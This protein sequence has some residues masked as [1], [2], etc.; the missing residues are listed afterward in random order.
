MPEMVAL[1][2]HVSQLL[3]MMSANAIVANEFPEDMSGLIGILQTFTGLGM[4]CGPILGSF[5]YAWGGF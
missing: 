2:L 3:L 5:L 4:L 1:T